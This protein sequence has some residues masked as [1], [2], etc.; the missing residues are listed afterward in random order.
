MKTKELKD[1]MM[2]GKFEFIDDRCYLNSENTAGLFLDVTSEP[3]KDSYKIDFYDYFNEFTL[4]DE[5]YNIV[6]DYV[7]KEFNEY[8]SSNTA[9]TEDDKEH[10]NSLIF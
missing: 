10:F 4:T 8:H 9:F 7:T 5:Q 3:E 6:C 1:L 2:S